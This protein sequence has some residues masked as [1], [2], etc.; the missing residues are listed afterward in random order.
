MSNTDF[1]DDLIIQIPNFFVHKTSGVVLDSSLLQN[2]K[3]VLDKPKDWLL[4]LGLKRDGIH[5]INVEADGV[6]TIKFKKTA[7][8][9][10]YLIGGA[11]NSVTKQFIYRTK[12][13]LKE[14]VGDYLTE[15]NQNFNPMNMNGTEDEAN[16][17]W[18]PADQYTNILKTR[19]DPD[20]NVNFVDDEP[21]LQT[22]PLDKNDEWFGFSPL[23]YVSTLLAEQEEITDEGCCWRWLL[24][25]DTSGH[26]NPFSL[27]ILKNIHKGG[28]TERWTWAKLLKVAKHYKRDL[29]LL[30][31]DF[32]PYRHYTSKDE[33]TEYVYI[34]E[35]KNTTKRKALVAQ[36]ANNHIYPFTTKFI[37]KYLKSGSSFTDESTAYGGNG[38]IIDNEKIQLSETE[39]RNKYKKKGPS[40]KNTKQLYQELRQL[41]SYMANVTDTI[42]VEEYDHSLFKKHFKLYINSQDLDMT[43]VIISKNT[44]KFYPIDSYNG[45][46]T[47]IYED[48]DDENGNRKKAW[49]I[50]AKPDYLIIKRVEDALIGKWGDIPPPLALGDTVSAIGKII[51]NKINK[52][53]LN[54]FKSDTLGNMFEV[55]RPYNA[56]YDILNTTKCKYGE[57]LER[58]FRKT[59]IPQLRKIMNANA[60]DMPI[61]EY[62]ETEKTKE[63]KAKLIMIEGK[64]DKE[65]ND[66]KVR[67]L[68]QYH[69]TT[70][71][72]LN[73]LV[74][75]EVEEIP[76]IRELGDVCSIDI[77]KCYSS[78]LE[79]I[80][81]GLPIYEPA[82]NVEDYDKSKMS[83]HIE[84]YLKFNVGM[85]YVE[86]AEADTF[87]PF[88][89][90]ES[91]WFSHTVM[92][93]AQ[94]SKADYTIKQMYLPHP[95]NILVPSAGKKFVRFVYNN[96][97]GVCL[98]EK[99]CDK[100]DCASKQIVNHFIGSL[101]GKGREQIRTKS[102]IVNSY[103]D[104]NYYK[105]KGHTIF[106]LPIIDGGQQLYLVGKQK[107]VKN[108]QNHC[109]WNKCIL[110][111]AKCLLNN[112]YDDIM[113]HSQE[114][115]WVSQ[116][117]IRTPDD[118][119]ND[120]LSKFGWHKINKKEVETSETIRE[121]NNYVDKWNNRE[122]ESN[123]IYREM[124][125]QQTIYPLRAKT[126]SFVFCDMGNG[127]LRKAISSAMSEETI[128]MKGEEANPWGI[129]RG[130]FRVEWFSNQDDDDR[131]KVLEVIKSNY[132]EPI[133]K[134]GM[135]PLQEKSKKLIT[136]DDIKGLI[137]RNEGLNLTGM[138]GTGKSF[139]LSKKI[140]PLL[141]NKKWALTATTHKAS[142]NDLFERLGLDG[143]TIDSF[144]RIP[145]AQAPKDPFFSMC[146]ELDYLMIDESSMIRKS[147]F[148]N[149]CHIKRLYP[150]LAII[151]I[152]DHQQLDPVESGGSVYKK[153]THTTNMAK[154]ITDYNS[155]H[156]TKNMRSSTEGVEM[157]NLYN[158]IIG[159]K[160]FGKNQ[161]FKDM[162]S[163]HT[164][165][166]KPIT[167][168]NT[169]LCWTN[170]TRQLIN[171][172]FV[173]LAITNKHN[174]VIRDEESKRIKTIW[175][176]MKVI[177]YPIMKDKKKGQ[178]PEYYNNQEF[179]VKKLH[180]TTDRYITL[181]C[182]I[183]G[184]ELIINKSQLDDFDYGYCITIHKSQGSSI[185]EKY[186][187]W[188]MDFVP[189]RELVYVGISRTTKKANCSIGTS[190][191]L[192][193]LKQYLRG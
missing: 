181:V 99:P 76:Q 189:H 102:H 169:H 82:D 22:Q 51:F 10:G 17:K 98:C 167:Q 125:T 180:T 27:Q 37:T 88:Q 59:Y 127:T 73:L 84:H 178:E 115:E 19:F 25:K 135:C 145:I 38:K 74:D 110:Q 40:D 62:I 162:V 177:A 106:G 151:L 113:I 152:G 176:K 134:V 137:D 147:I 64:I 71:R 31:L 7:I 43:Y 161:T 42:F 172:C 182:S 101:G 85:Y 107:V 58:S 163:T 91:E 166:T 192:R 160:D 140:I 2:R 174:L 138:A 56:I 150:K 187:L 57:Y 14:Q 191:H 95:S 108:S 153:M 29:V 188:E 3:K 129:G 116:S 122:N 123:S 164:N 165:M 121:Y 23:K 60:T 190:A 156:L 130:K 100:Q 154:F 8:S 179:V 9:N 171:K 175:E 4:P 81:G 47:K 185:D 41:E 186:F 148:Y 65:E 69:Q 170:D 105:N 111:Q 39:I 157:F 45:R 49:T 50:E 48:I 136:M 109:I 144:L 168:S 34:E 44:N 92:F 142:H 54:N 11:K 6:T 55:E 24:S 18:Y 158:T 93:N 103:P 46:I 61:N 112:M 173:K 1:I 36:Y 114:T 26:S 15:L 97:K 159:G 70:T 12:D 66:S 77:N 128:N 30:D 131:T 139:T 126:D 89:N 52:L 141:A 21:Y 120:K 155:L 117:K 67:L 75:K 143:K 13:G 20:F 72:Q 87:V 90:V 133:L 53:N 118:P 35:D 33:Y 16:Q 184:K 83:P 79:N 119:I 32:K 68:N 63:L 146:K 104:A 86:V 5:F 96:L 80:Q 183:T 149:L 94:F 78:V 28:T 124:I 193:G 132:V